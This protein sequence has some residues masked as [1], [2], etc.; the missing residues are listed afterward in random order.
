[1][2]FRGK[3]TNQTSENDEKP[4]FGAVFDPFGPNFPPLPIF[5]KHLLGKPAINSIGISIYTE[6]SKKHLNLYGIKVLSLA[7]FVSAICW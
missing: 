2:Q 1:M 3:L 5:G 7:K 4:N 6:I